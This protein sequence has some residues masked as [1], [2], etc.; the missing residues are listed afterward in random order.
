MFTQMV[1][2]RSV[3]V[4][5][6]GIS[7][8][9]VNGTRGGQHGQVSRYLLIAGAGVKRRVYKRGS[10]ARVPPNTLYPFQ[11]HLQ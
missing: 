11:K 8:V 2:Y 3:F 7:W 10:T 1:V 9:A 5:S 6:S 4:V